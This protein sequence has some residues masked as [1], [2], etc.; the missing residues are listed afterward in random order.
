MGYTHYWR[1]HLA[2]KIEKSAWDG[3]RADVHNILS[4]SKVPVSN[5]QGKKGA[6]I[7]SRE[8]AFNGT[9]PDDYETFA[10]TRNPKPQDWESDKTQVFEFCKTARNPYDVVVVAVLL[11]AKD[12][13]GKALTVTSDGSVE[14][15]EKGFRLASDALNRDLPIRS[16]CDFGKLEGPALAHLEKLE[17]DLNFRQP[18]LQAAMGLDAVL[19][20]AEKAPARPRRF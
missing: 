6:N 1:R 15:W 16:V 7:N 9:P 8:I 14:D 18:A 2:V 17:S 13:L 12:R 20:E 11:A 4:A 5:F 3:L 19:P 10:L